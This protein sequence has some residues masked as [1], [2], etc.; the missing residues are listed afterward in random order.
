MAARL[1]PQKSSPDGTANPALEGDAS[2]KPTPQRGPACTKLWL[3][4][5][6]SLQPNRKRCWSTALQKLLLQSFTAETQRVGRACS[7]LRAGVDDVGSTSRLGSCPLRSYERGYEPL[8]LHWLSNTTKF[9]RGYGM[10]NMKPGQKLEF[11]LPQIQ[12]K[13][14]GCAPLLLDF[15]CSGF[16]FPTP[17]SKLCSM[18]RGSI[19]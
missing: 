5:K 16:L 1:A 2:S 17:T 13:I 8:V 6:S 7:P 15:I 11:L 19:P 4:W 14:P 10:D 3:T 9:R 12:L 18:S